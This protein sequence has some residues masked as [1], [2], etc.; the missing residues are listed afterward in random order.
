RGGRGV[1]DGRRGV[2]GGV[3]GRLLRRDRRVQRGERRAGFALTCDRVGRRYTTLGDERGADHG[4]AQLV[5]IRQAV[6]L[7]LRDLHGPPAARR[8]P[9]PAAS[10][11]GGSGA[12]PGGTT[13]RRPAA[14]PPR[15]L[16][17]AGAPASA[18]GRYPPATPVP[19]PPLPYFGA[20]RNS[21]EISPDAACVA[22]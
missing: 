20:Y 17:R 11:G 1:V 5:L 3:V 4:Q 10:G 9:R 8:L 6:R 15:S 21:R 14:A 12:R 18:P 7:P 22:P 13:P 19:S 2:G 16:G